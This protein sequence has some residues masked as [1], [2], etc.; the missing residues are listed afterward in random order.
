M[1]RADLNKILSSHPAWSYASEA[2]KKSFARIHKH[3]DFRSD[4]DAAEYRWDV[5]YMGWISAVKS[6]SDTVKGE[7]PEHDVGSATLSW[8]EEEGR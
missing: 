8:L 2:S 4:K 7:A 5:F 3:T 1:K 6:L